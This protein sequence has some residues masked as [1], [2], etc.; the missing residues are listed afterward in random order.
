MG[1]N[2]V[3]MPSDLTPVVSELAVALWRLD[4]RLQ[5][6]EL[7]LGSRASHNVG[8][9]RETL[10]RMWSLLNENDV[11]IREHLGERFVEGS[12]LTVVHI[13][14]PAGPLQVIETLKP[15]V[16]VCGEIISH[17]QVVLG[18]QENGANGQS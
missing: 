8:A 17:G 9:V 4:R 14:D 18:S 13:Q 6:L 2:V 11:E 3:R 10:N 7:E 15:S 5:L 16:V 12:A 1:R